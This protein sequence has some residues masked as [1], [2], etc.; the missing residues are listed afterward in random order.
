LFFSGVADK[1]F[2]SLRGRIAA[3]LKNKKQG[4]G[5]RFFYKQVTPYGV[6]ADPERQC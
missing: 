4:G 3:P 6:C 2:A 5:C 1:S